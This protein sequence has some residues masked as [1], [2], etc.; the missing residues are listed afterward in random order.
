MSHVFADAA[1]ISRER[2]R[3]REREIDRHRESERERE[4]QRER[5]RARDRYSAAF[6]IY[7]TRYYI[8]AVPVSESQIQN[9]IFNPKVSTFGRRRLAQC[10]LGSDH[11][12]LTSWAGW[13]AGSCWPLNPSLENWD[14][15]CNVGLAGRA[16]PLLNTAGFQA[17]PETNLTATTKVTT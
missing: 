14:N 4:S 11:I 6:Q 3:E 5:E 17:L 7:P 16:L 12:G 13:F 8:R 15:I 10:V 9:L 1:K 2:E